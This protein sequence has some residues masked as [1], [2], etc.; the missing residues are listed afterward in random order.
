MPIVSSS[1]ATPS[2][3]RLLSIALPLDATTGAQPAAAAELAKRQKRVSL[4]REIIAEWR[5]EQ[6]RERQRERS[7]DRD[8]GMER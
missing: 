5:Q 4:A 1:G 3:S 2:A 7:R 8:Q 6:A